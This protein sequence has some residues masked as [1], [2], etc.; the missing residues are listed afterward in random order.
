MD[1]KKTYEL[2]EGE[3]N[4]KV[5]NPIKSME[6]KSQKNEAEMVLNILLGEEK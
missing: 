6:P 5:V 1:D 2:I 4:E 3:S